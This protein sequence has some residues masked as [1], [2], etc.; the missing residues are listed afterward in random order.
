MPRAGAARS[1]TGS[2]PGRVPSPQELPRPFLLLDGGRSCGGD[3]RDPVPGVQGPECGQVHRWA[4]RE[5][6]TDSRVLV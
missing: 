1:P 2:R 4:S 6:T 3:Q 5:G